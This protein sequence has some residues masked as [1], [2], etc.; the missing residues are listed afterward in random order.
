MGSFEPM[1]GYGGASL[2]DNLAPEAPACSLLLNS[3]EPIL[4]SAVLFPWVCFWELT[5][6]QPIAALGPPA[7][8][9]LGELRSVTSWLPVFPLILFELLLLRMGL[10]HFL[11]LSLRRFYLYSSTN[12]F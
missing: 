7:G 3:P 9:F 4:V 6:P 12:A 8:T 11:A 10:L 5:N 1:V 2:P